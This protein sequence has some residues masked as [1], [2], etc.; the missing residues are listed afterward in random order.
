[1]DMLKT[2]LEIALSMGIINAV[3]WCFRMCI[4]YMG[5]RRLQRIEKLIFKCLSYS[6][7]L[8]FHALRKESVEVDKVIELG[9]KQRAES[10]VM[11]KTNIENTFNLLS[12]FSRPLNLDPFGKELNYK[13]YSGEIRPYYQIMQLLHQETRSL[14]EELLD[15]FEESGHEI[16][17]DFLA[18]D[19]GTPYPFLEEHSET[20]TVFTYSTMQDKYVSLFSDIREVEKKKYKK[21]QKFFSFF[22]LIPAANSWF[23][24]HFAPPSRARIYKES[25][26]LKAGHKELR[27][28]TGTDTLDLLRA[29]A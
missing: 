19:Y 5:L 21:L 20:T 14:K 18:W 12:S 15:I 4:C 25:D 28:R 23:Q 27:R 22:I 11:S 2:V 1:M 9:N 17:C 24:L 7:L 8:F 26:K 16:D 29:S 10:A 13:R 6:N 3:F